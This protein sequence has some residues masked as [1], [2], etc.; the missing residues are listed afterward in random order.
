MKRKISVLIFSLLSVVYPCLAVNSDLNVDNLSVFKDAT[1]YGSLK[2]SEP[3]CQ[4]L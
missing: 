2:T 1:F 4:V 3:V